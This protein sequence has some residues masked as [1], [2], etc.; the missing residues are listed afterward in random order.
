MRISDWSSDVCSSDLVW[1]SVARTE[2]RL[3]M[4]WLPATTTQ[5]PALD[6]QV[7]DPEAVEIHGVQP[8]EV[9]RPQLVG[10]GHARLRGLHAGLD[11]HRAAADHR[12]P[13]SQQDMA[14]GD[15]EP[16]DI[17]AVLLAGDVHVGLEAGI[18][19]PRLAPPRP[20]P[21]RRAPVRESGG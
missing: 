5:S 12:P 9:A 15:G 19:A 2:M 20:P 6:R 1:I 7:A 16:L 21:P 14:A 11:D 18:A 17:E 10:L 13:Q 8:V 4:P 3:T